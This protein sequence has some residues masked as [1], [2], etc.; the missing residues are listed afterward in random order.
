MALLILIFLALVVP[1]VINRTTELPHFI[2]R[3]QLRK[4]WMLI[5]SVLSIY[6]LWEQKEMVVKVQQ[7][8]R[9]DAAWIGYALAA[10]VGASVFMGYWWMTGTILKPRMDVTFSDSP[11]WT[12]G[13]KR[14]VATEFAAVKDYL[15]DLGFTL[16]LHTPP[17]QIGARDFMIGGPSEFGFTISMTKATLDDRIA[18]RG[19]YMS[20][21][22][23][24][25]LHV[26][27]TDLAKEPNRWAAAL[28]FRAYFLSSFS[29]TDISN[30]RSWATVLWKLR[31]ETSQDFMDHAMFFSVKL[32][33][34]TRADPN[35]DFDDY[36]R[37]HVERGLLVMENPG[38]TWKQKLDDAVQEVFCAVPLSQPS[39]AATA[40]E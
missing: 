2:K 1:P 9:Y 25:L 22:F 39:V 11:E 32:F 17:V 31:N 35:G 38:V 6:A 36:F 19:A 40:P 29:D 10:L 3:S 16:P 15:V 5:L 30:K 20:Y 7:A 34:Q 13:R 26:S 14:F 23:H 24:S 8:F 37:N 4:F 33:D 18:V 28:F 21:V 12:A 27:K